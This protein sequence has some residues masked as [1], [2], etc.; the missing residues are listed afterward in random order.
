[1]DTAEQGGI[2]NSG[3]QSPAGQHSGHT[4]SVERV[5]GAPAEAIFDAF[6]AMYDSQR[7]DWVTDSQLDLRPGGR[8]RVAF[9]VPDGPAFTEERVITTVERPHRLAYNMTAVYDSA[10]GFSTSVEVKIEA[11]PGG[12]RVRLVQQGFPTASA[13]DDFAGAW[14]DVLN[15]LARRVSPGQP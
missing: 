6:I 5:I 2:V 9:Q 12:H 10:P 11:V 13:R 1:M 3:E 4:L 15:E 8:W 7:P 14:P